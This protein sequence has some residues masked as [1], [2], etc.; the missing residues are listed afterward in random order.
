MAGLVP[1]RLSVRPHIARHQGRVIRRD[2]WP[3]R[4]TR[5]RREC[6]TVGRRAGGKQVVH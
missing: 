3:G 4:E 1:L 5:R 2:V 6:G